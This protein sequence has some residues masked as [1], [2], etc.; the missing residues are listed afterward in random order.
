MG[1]LASLP[2]DKHVKIISVAGPYRSGKSFLMNRALGQMRGFDIGSTVQSCTKG[3]WIWNQPI[4][5]ANDE[6]ENVTLLIDTEGLFSS[7]RSTDT[8]LKLFA[9]T[10]LLSSSF[11]YNQ[12]GPINES[13]LSDMQLVVNLVNYFGN[14]SEAKGGNKMSEEF[15]APDFYWTLRDFYHDIDEF[16]TFDAYMEDCLKLDLDS[17]SSE[18]LKKNQVRKLITSFF[19]QRRCFAMVRPVD[20]ANQLAHI[21]DLDWDAGDIKNEFKVVCDDLIENLKETTRVK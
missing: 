7:E 8:D 20:D 1:F 2:R 12:M 5:D 14:L 21:E 16:E 13:A 4:I 9:L 15:Q 10:I 17:V 11:I 3:V 18:S 19:K 6:D